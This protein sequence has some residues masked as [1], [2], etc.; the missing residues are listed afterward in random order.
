VRLLAAARQLLTVT[1]VGIV[2][3]I[4]RHRPLTYPSNYC[5]LDPGNSDVSRTG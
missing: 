5:A 1:G 3:L 4:G 2:A